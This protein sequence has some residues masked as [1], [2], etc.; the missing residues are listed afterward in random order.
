MIA[1]AVNVCRNAGNFQSMQMLENYDVNDVVNMWSKFISASHSIE[2]DA[3]NR[4]IRAMNEFD[5][6]SLVMAMS[7]FQ[8][9]S[10]LFGTNFKKRIVIASSSSGDI[11]DVVEAL[12]TLRTSQKY[13][14]QISSPSGKP[15]I[16][17]V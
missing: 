13:T 12:E 14:E 3:I 9:I 4:C 16:F 5:L 7:A 8:I 10:P 1:I 11:A 15:H 2:S 17:Y 6:D